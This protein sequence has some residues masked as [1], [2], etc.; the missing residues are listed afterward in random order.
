[1]F[2]LSQCYPLA[3]ADPKQG[4]TSIL[5]VVTL[6]RRHKGRK[7]WLQV[8]YH[9]CPKIQIYTD[10]ERRTSWLEYMGRRKLIALRTMN[11]EMERIKAVQAN[12]VNPAALPAPAG[13]RGVTWGLGSMNLAPIA[14]PVAPSAASASAIM[15][16]PG[17]ADG[18]KNVEDSLYPQH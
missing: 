9:I 6:T 7:D 11:D 18:F 4:A 15:M 17:M 16:A 8:V 13:L 5:L 1:M 3:S 10:L 12:Q 2:R 14:P